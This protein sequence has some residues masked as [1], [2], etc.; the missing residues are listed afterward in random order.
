MDKEYDYI[1]K[2][3]RL[4]GMREARITG[5]IPKFK[6]K[7]QIKNVTD[8]MV[9]IAVPTCKSLKELQT[10]LILERG[11]NQPDYIIRSGWKNQCMGVVIHG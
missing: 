1:I 10:N 3:G 7:Y 4:N 2:W 8:T 6:H 9:T 11:I 5:L